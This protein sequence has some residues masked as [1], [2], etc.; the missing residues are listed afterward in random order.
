MAAERAEEFL[1]AICVNDASQMHLRDSNENTYD[2]PQ[3]SM[4][5]SG[6]RAPLESE[7]VVTFF[8]K[9]FS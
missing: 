2:H 1:E 3:P 4:Q 5:W 9:P 8:P 6:I 7:E